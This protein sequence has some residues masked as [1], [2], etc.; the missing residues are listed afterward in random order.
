MTAVLVTAFM[1]MNFNRN[2]KN[3]DATPNNSLSFEY[4]KTL[5]LKLH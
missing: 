5:Q 4:R 1:V 2:D 3:K